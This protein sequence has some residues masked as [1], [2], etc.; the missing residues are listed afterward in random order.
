MHA[1]FFLNKVCMHTK[2]FYIWLR[3]ENMFAR[4]VQVA[5]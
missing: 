1:E 4:W 3:S 2:F 5:A